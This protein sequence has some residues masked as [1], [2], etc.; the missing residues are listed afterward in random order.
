MAEIQTGRLETEHSLLHWKY[1]P[2]DMRVPVAQFDVSP[3]RVCECP[4]L[5]DKIRSSSPDASLQRCLGNWV[6]SP[7]AKCISNEGQQN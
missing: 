5:H 1:T 6:V 7:A 2:K 3:S 4:A